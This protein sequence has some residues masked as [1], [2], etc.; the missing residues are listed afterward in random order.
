MRCWLRSMRIIPGPC[1]LLLQKDGSGAPIHVVWGIPK[2]HDRP[3][4]LVTVYR[5]DPVRWDP[6]FTRRRSQWSQ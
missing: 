6:S 2:G 3:A 4:V 1:A 5:P